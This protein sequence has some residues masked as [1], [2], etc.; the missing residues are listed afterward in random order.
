MRHLDALGA[1]AMLEC[2]LLT[3]IVA[4]SARVAATSR[5][6]EKAARLGEVLA[7]LEPHEARIGVAYLCGQTLQGRLGVGPALVDDALA[8]AAAPAPL[9]TLSEVDAAFSRISRLV[10]KGS[11]LERRVVLAELFGRATGDEQSFLARLIFGELRQGALEGVVLEAVARCARVPLDRLRRA[12]MLGGDL[13]I[14]AA[15]AL[16]EGAAGVARFGLKLMTPVRPMLAQPAE[17][18]EEALA[19]IDDAGAELKMDGARIQLHKDGEDVRI[20]SRALNEVTVAVPD[21]VGAARALPARRL[22]LDG[23]AMTF[24]ARGRPHPFQ[25]TMKRFGSRTDLQRLQRELPLLPFFFDCLHLDGSDLIDESGR[26]RLA[27]LQETLPAGLLMPRQAVANADEA[28]AFLL[29]ALETGHEGIMIKSLNAPYEAGARGGSWLKVKQA[30][31]LDLVV[32]AA[33]WGSGRRR[34]SLSNLHL[35]A[36][37]PAGGGFV[38]LG[39]TFKG[40][41]DATLRWQTDKLLELEIGREGHVVH[42]R[43]ELV[44]EIAFNDVQTSPHYPGGMALRFARVK[45]YRSDKTAAEADTIDTVR[46]IHVRSMGHA[47]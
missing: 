25:V 14:V 44:V 21:I 27:L 26:R 30:H 8:V 5:R 35:G 41:T 34:G 31:T 42:V 2:M 47:P 9:L 40:L 29:R 1:T 4:C 36:R 16:A 32:L 43:P 33:E 11:A 23:E 18:L 6:L 45:G 24:D 13:P 3:D 15:A 12:V 17:D 46:A 39:K 20:F 22:V 38:M 7:R 19:G 28:R 37:D 10:G